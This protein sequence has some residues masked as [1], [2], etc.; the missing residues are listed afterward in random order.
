MFIFYNTIYL[1][2]GRLVQLVRTRD[3]HSRGQGF[4][5]STAH[6]AAR[7]QKRI[8]NTEGFVFSSVFSELY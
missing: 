2:R 7:T 8:I 1:R 4:E 3:L 6:F 5:S